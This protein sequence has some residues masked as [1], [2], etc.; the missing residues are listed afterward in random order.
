MKKED[1]VLSEEL[2]TAEYHAVFRYA[3]TLTRNENDAHD[4]TQEAF[5][6]AIKHR[7]RFKGCSSIYTWLCSIAKNVWRSELSRR[8][9]HSDSPLTEEILPDT[10]P[11]LEQT[12]DDGDMSLRIHKC[13]HR[14]KEP[15]KEV[16]SLRVFGGLPFTSIA[17]LFS[18]TES[19]ARVTYHRARNML[20]DD[21][22]KEKLL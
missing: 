4:I 12:V 14:L 13:L 1:F 2:L 15:Y 19:W 10:S 5:L 16:F 6:Q 17:L 18:K 3:L 11:S 8:N 7:D 20:T 21:L 9:R 22:R